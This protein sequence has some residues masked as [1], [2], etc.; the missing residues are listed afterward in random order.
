MKTLGNH[1]FGVKGITMRSMVLGDWV[2]GSVQ[3]V[4]PSERY[5]QERDYGG[6]MA[7][8]PSQTSI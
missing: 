7:A 8:T 4:V 5:A 6:L 2:F 3:V 1:P